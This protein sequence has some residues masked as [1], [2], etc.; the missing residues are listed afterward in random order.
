MIFRISIVHLSLA[1]A[2]VLSEC[3]SNLVSGGIPRWSNS[4]RFDLK[5]INTTEM[6][7]IAGDDR[8]VVE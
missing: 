4:I 3:G 5:T 7:D 1:E 2:A 6:V 8:F